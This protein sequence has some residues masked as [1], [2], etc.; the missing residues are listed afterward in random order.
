M[1]DGA[2]P[3]TL[4][5]RWLLPM[6]GPPLERG[7]LTIQAD[8]VVAVEPRGHLSPDL[9]LG[10]AIVLPGFVNCH[11]HLDLSAL[12][13][14]VLPDAGFT[15]WLG[16]IT[17]YRRTATADDTEKAVA[18]GIREIVATGTTMVGDVAGSGRS[19][20]ALANAPLRATVFYE[21]LG[22]TQPR[23]R[24]AW[25][26][27]QTWY[28]S[29]SDARTSRAGLSPH[30]PYSVRRSLFRLAGAS[31]ARGGVPLSIHLA[32]SA[33]EA[34][35]LEAR[36]GQ[37]VEF[38]RSLGVWDPDGLVS[39]HQT[40]LDF[41]R[42]DYP[43]LLVHANYLSQ[44][45]RVPRNASIIFCPRTHSAFGHQRHPVCE[46]QRAGIRVALGTDGLASNPDLDML[47][48]ARFLH[49]H[50]PQIPP[51]EVLRML[52]LTGAEALGRQREAGSLVPGKSADLVVVPLA[53]NGKDP[54]E[55]LLQSDAPVRATLFRGRWV[56][57]D[58]AV[59]LD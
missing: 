47:A 37:L 9:D 23:A 40:I 5:A 36:Q 55:Q 16:R 15:D 34:D 17:R 43:V 27:F 52:T 30:A 11:T 19:W 59:D 18:A 38:L 10:D 24:L 3:W 12:R 29:R 46:F 8:R 35:L 26:E 53:A 13:G 2:R 21:V 51:C 41:C 4:T 1:L 25:Q 50:Y 58:P 49:R 6:E 33:D 20:S 54:A 14:K 28:G 57:G 45:A 56:A 32:E 22:L 7:T 44:S 48:E 31:A 39:S 42:G